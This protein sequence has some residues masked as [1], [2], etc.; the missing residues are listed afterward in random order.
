MADFTYQALGPLTPG[1]ERAYLGLQIDEFGRAEPVVLVWLPEYA[2]KD[3]D[4]RIR[5]IRENERASVLEHPNIVK[6]HG[7]ESLGDRMARVV[8]FSD[9]EPLRKVLLAFG[10]KLP[11]EIALRVVAD[12]C[13]GVHFAHEAG[14]DDGTPMLHGDIRP[15]TVM[16][17]FNGV[18]KVSGY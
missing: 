17:G 7:L 11:P 6:V 9:G 16:V 12:A 13:P 18:A 3:P 10:G 14:N 5:V 4:L 8:E 2:V 1:S 15:E